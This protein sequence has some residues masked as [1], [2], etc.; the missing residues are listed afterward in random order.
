MFLAILGAGKEA[1]GPLGNSGVGWGVMPMAHA[2]ILGGPSSSKT[3]LETWAGP[4]A[5]CLSSSSAGVPVVSQPFRWAC[6]GFLLH[7]CLGWFRQD[8]LAL[9]FGL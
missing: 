8:V 1:K 6:P 3:A 7:F 5:F 9:E 4:F 2:A